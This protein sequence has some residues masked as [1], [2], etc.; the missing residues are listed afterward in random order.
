MPNWLLRASRLLRLTSRLDSQRLLLFDY[1]THPGE[2]L[3]ALDP[4]KAVS[5]ITPH[6]AFPEDFR[7]KAEA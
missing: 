1:L 6:I 3:D 7:P 2:K 5:P 4:A